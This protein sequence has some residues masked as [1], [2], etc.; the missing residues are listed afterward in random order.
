MTR[1]PVTRQQKAAV[2]TEQAAAAAELLHS[3]DLR[4]MPLAVRAHY[5]ELRRLSQALADEGIA[6]L[7]ADVPRELKRSA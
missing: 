4:P 3:I 1:R 2:V 7:K 5:R 6:T